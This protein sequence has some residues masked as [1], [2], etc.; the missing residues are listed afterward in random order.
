MNALWGRRQ[1]LQGVSLTTRSDGCNVFP[2]KN[3]AGSRV[4]PRPAEPLI[5]QRRA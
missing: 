3:A 1:R 4:I 2:L 5:P